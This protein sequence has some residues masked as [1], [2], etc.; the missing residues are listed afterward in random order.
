MNKK[1]LIGIMVVVIVA[2]IFGIYFFLFN[3]K[4]QETNEPVPQINESV[5]QKN[6][7]STLTDLDE[8][9]KAMV[10][11]LKLTCA[12]FLKGDLSGNPASDCPGFSKQI[13]KDLCFYCYAVKNQNSELCARIDDESALS[14]LCKI[15]NGTPFE[16]IIKQ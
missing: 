11:S 16:D 8:S 1:I 13:N 12:D 5:A 7:E 4:K 15:A 2:V 3:P 9:T 14:S 10:E 6:K